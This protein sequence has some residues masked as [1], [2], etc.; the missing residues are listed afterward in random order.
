MNKTLLIILSLGLFWACKTESTSKAI[1]ELNLELS[2]QIDKMANANKQMQINSIRFM[3]ASEEQQKMHEEVQAKVMKN[4]AD[5]IDEIISK[6]GFPTEIL[7]GKKSADSF[8][9][10][11]QSCSAYPNI[12]KKAIDAYLSTCKSMEDSIQY[13]I[14]LDKY[15]IENQA[16]SPF[17]IHV[18]YNEQGQAFVPNKHADLENN[19]AAYKMETLNKYLNLK[20]EQY[21]QVNAA[22]LKAKGIDSPILYD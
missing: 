21:Y 5:A 14:L 12:K 4:N 22:Q 3:Q 18:H 15:A 2:K 9:G 17:G 8:L 10:L 19:R 6:H 7:V 13:A 20:T 1:P 11:V 16:A